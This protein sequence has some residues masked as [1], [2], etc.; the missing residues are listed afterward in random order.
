MP[1]SNPGNLSFQALIASTPADHLL[2]SVRGAQFFLVDQLLMTFKL[3]SEL[4]VAPPTGHQLATTTALEQ[5]KLYSYNNRPVDLLKG[6]NLILL[7]C[8]LPRCF[9]DPAGFPDKTNLL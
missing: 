1:G 4:L 5:K 6:C 2:T 3:L 9:W 7:N 8:S